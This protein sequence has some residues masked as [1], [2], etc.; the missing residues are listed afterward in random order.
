M[1]H[2]INCLLLS[3]LFSC[4]ILQN[5]P[6]F[7][8]ENDH[9][10]IAWELKDWGY[11]ISEV[12]IKVEGKWQ[13]LPNPSGEYTLIRSETKPE[14]KSEQPYQTTT[15]QKFP[16]EI[17]K[18]QTEHWKEQVNS[19]ALNTAGKTIE[20]FP[21][22]AQPIGENKI[23]FKKKTDWG[24]VMITWSLDPKFPQDILIEENL[25]VSQD[26]FYSLSSPILLIIPEADLEWAAVPGYFHGNKLESNLVLGYGYGNGVPSSPIVFS[27]KT[28][29]TLSP[30]I[31]SKQGFTLALIS[32][33]ELGRDPWKKDQMSHND[34]N[35]GLSH[36]NRQAKLTPSI[37]YPVLG[38]FGSEKKTGES[39]NFGFRFSLSDRDWFE[40]LNHAVYNVFEFE[41]GL[42]LRKNRQSLSSRVNEMYGYLTDPETSLW[43]VEDYEGVKIGAQAYLG[44]VVGSD[45]DAMKNADYGAMW[46]LANATGSSYLKGKVLP[47][48]LNFKLAQQQ[49]SGGFFQG[50]AIGQYFLSKPKIFVEEWGKMVEPIALTY[51]I[52]LD[53]GNILLFEPENEELKK[54]LTL[55]ADLLLDWQK[56]DGS[57]AVAYSREEEEIF[58]ELQDFR[59]TFYGLLVAHRILKDQ[60]YLE[61]AIRG[62]DWYLEN[63]VKN[64][65]FLGVCGDMRYAPDFATG[66]TAQAFLDLFDMTGDEKYQAAAIQAAKIYT[67]YIYTHPIPSREIKTVNGK[68][69]QDWEIAQAGLSFEHGGTLGSANFHGPILLASHAGMFIR[70]HQL[71]GERIFADMARS[72]AIGRHAFVDEKTSVASYYWKGM[73]S[74]AGPFPHH[75]WWQVGW[76]TDYLFS[77]IELRSN[78]KITFPR[79][80]IT[81][82]V[83]PHQSYGFEAGKIF[84]EKAFQKIV[85]DAVSVSNPSIEYVI[86]SSEKGDKIWVTLLNQ[87]NESQSGDLKIDFTPFQSGKLLSTKVL[88]YNGSEIEKKEI[89]A[90]WEISVPAMGLIVLEFEF[91]KNP[92]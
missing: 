36:M 91:E 19:V 89:K 28:A 80:F 59:P 73:N 11:K 8:L 4:S 50:A 45:K 43:R 78:G 20:F 68:Q 51:Y 46:M 30:I 85:P 64:G 14:E 47:Y 16:E 77:E 24:T 66:Q 13:T 60:K 38:E 3:L 61:A 72:A 42:N 9:L 6:D 57:W 70:M 35:V 39:L 2:L 90:E 87:E 71:T 49:T 29:T 75:A 86:A 63:G 48:A 54:R 53:I 76:I 1:K 27:E 33:P 34:C 56:E 79:G 15:G 12:A 7:I 23:Q 44:G 25:E 17:Y 18:Y 40:T 10:K 82:K 84:G 52:M 83:G 88:D 65:S 26:G 55:G 21:D 81:P 58:L 92:L 67:T 74:G 31:S 69:I 32:N 62:A 41:K 5:E 22:E 37:Y